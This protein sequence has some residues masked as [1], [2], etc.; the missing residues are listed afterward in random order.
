MKKLKL[1]VFILAGVLLLLQLVPV[2]RT[3]PEAKSDIQVTAGFKELLRRS[4]YDCH[5]YETR[6]PWY[7]RVAPVS[8]LVVH[9]VKEARDHLNF[10]RWEEYSSAAR[11]HLHER[12]IDEVTKREMPLSRYLILHP[13]ARIYPAELEMFTQWIVTDGG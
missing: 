9:D 5:S 6:W 7:S 13:E 2:S 8:W 3:N 1:S 12:I 10:S 11:E 4:C